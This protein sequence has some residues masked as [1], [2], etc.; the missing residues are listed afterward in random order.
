MQGIKSVVDMKKDDHT[1]SF[2]LAETLKYLYLLFDKV[3][4][5]S[6]VGAGWMQGWPAVWDGC[7][8]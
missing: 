5:R 6:S 7:S 3:G 8:L 4:A 1:P 2:F